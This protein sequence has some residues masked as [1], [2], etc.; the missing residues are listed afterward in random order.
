M[1]SA[2]DPSLPTGIIAFLLAL[3]C[4]PEAPAGPLQLT[5]A[6][7][8][9]TIYSGDS[10]A[11]RW[12]VRNNGAPRTF[13]DFAAFY[14]FTVLGPDGSVIRPEQYTRGYGVFGE[15]VTTLGPG[16]EVSHVVD[17]RCV[18][19]AFTHGECTL[20]YRLAEPGGYQIVVQH[21]P[22]PPPDGSQ[23]LEFLPSQP[24][25]VKLHVLPRSASRVR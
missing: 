24:D 13:R 14:V 12:T 8:R 1:R 15:Q 5:A 21:V 23:A 10:L 22:L 11:V 4:A 3:G 20:G 16:D 6:A 19:Q 17:L 9:D 25:T 2:R 18:P 7:V